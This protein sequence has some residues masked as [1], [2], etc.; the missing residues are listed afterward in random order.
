MFDELEVEYRCDCSRTRIERALITLG[1]S[2]LE[3]MLAEQV[4]EGKPEELEVGCRFCGRKEIFT[5]EDIVKMMKKANG[6]T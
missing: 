2:D 3:K 5:R 1:E 4:A 6:K